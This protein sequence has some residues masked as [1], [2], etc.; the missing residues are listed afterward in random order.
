MIWKDRLNAWCSKCEI[1]LYLQYK[2][3][4]EYN[5][6]DKRMNIC[7][8]KEYKYS[9]NQVLPISF[10]VHQSGRNSKEI[11]FFYYKNVDIDFVGQVYRIFV[12]INH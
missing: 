11:D 4:Y 12:K 10:S 3:T 5:C 8:N 9:S 1:K 2:S 7:M 6:D